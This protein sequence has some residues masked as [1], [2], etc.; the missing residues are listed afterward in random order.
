MSLLKALGWQI[1]WYYYSLKLKYLG[2]NSH[3]HPSSN[4]HGYTQNISIGNDVLVCPNVIIGCDSGNSFIRIGNNTVIN[5]YCMILTYG[6]HIIIG[7]YCNINPFSILY[8][9]GGLQIGNN[10]LIA[11][12]TVIIPS[13]HVFEDKNKL[14]RLQGDT[15]KGIVIED[16]VW[17][18]SGCKILDGLTIGKG[19]VIGAGSVVTK[20]VESYSVVVGVPGKVLKRRDE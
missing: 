8:G 19:A 9:H 16:D 2:S 1:I 17:I 20:D 13:N 10:V 15:K 4:L 5:H 6:G 3:I 7:D 14:I 12:H 18:G 11:A